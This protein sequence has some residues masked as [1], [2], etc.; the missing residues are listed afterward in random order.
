MVN[1]DEIKN[2]L[3]NLMQINPNTAKL[4]NLPAK[5]IVNTPD[6]LIK[7]LTEEVKTYSLTLFDFK[8]HFGFI[9]IYRPKNG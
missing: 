8:L 6:D 3:N 7:Q 2:R 9:G 4:S 5:Q 1:D